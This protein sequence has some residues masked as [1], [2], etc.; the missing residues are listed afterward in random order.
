MSNT[1]VQPYL[2][3]GGR[4]EEAIAFYSSAIGATLIM[5]M[6]FNEN[7]DPM[8]PGSLP[9]GFENKIMHASLRVG[10]STIMASD[11][12]HAGTVFNGFSLSLAV[13][14]VDEANRAFAAL[15]QGGKVS[16]PMSKTFWSPAF[17]MLEDRFGVSWMVTVA[18]ASTP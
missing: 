8:P 17:G 9:P 13:N 12:C 5:A 15:A 10:N 18:D 6:R 4:C 1:V 16:M 11:G 2:T 7:P 3:F 14:N